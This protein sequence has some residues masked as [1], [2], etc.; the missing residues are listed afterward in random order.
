MYTFIFIA[1]NMF[2]YEYID[3]HNFHRCTYVYTS[4]YGRCMYISMG[5]FIIQSS[6]PIF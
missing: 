2:I 4:I 6:E 3:K 1:L 5:V